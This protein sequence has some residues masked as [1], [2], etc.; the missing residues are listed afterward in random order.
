MTTQLTACNWLTCPQPKPKAR[1]RLFCFP[2]AGATVTA[3]RT[4]IN[5]LPQE[6]EIYLVQLPGRGSRLNEKP[7]TKLSD[8]VQTLVPILQ[9]NLNIPFA[10][11]G[12]SLGALLS[13]EIACQLRRQN[14]PS[15]V[16]LFTCCSPAPQKPNL[17]PP[18]HTLPTT[19]F[20]T[21]LRDRYNGIPLSI[22]R[23]REL[24]QLFL[25]SLRA[26]MEMLETYCYQP[27]KPL[28]CPISAFGGWQDLAVCSCDLAEWCD[29]TCSFF[30]LRMFPGNH[31]FLHNNTSTFLQVLYQQLS[32]LCNFK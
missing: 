6:V 22:S 26:D 27:E 32:Q 20:L 3:Y 12:H 23:D 25:P 10:F 1:L 2:C 16:Y 4:W 24:M 30:T 14:C 29:R 28:E 18:I 5:K 8:L 7:F 21:Q 11:F 31:F 15:P 19:P 13:F 9:P 17:N